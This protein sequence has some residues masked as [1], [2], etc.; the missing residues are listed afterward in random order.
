MENAS[1]INAPTPSGAWDTSRLKAGHEVWRLAPTERD[2]ARLWSAA[3]GPGRE[4]DPVWED[5]RARIRTGLDAFGFTLVRQLFPAGAVADVRQEADVTERVSR[6]VRDFGEIVPQNGAGD[7]TQVL[8]HREG[9]PDEIA[10]HC[11]TCDLLVL[12]CL[13]PAARGGAT[14]VAGAPYIHDVLAAERPDV[15]ELLGQEWHFDRSGRAGSQLV[16]TPILT[17][18]PDGAVTCYYQ[19]RTVR[20]SAGRDGRPPLDAARAEALDVLDEVLNRPETAYPVT[21]TSGDLLIIRNSRVMHGR[22]PFTDGPEPH[23]R[24]VLRL[25]LDEVAA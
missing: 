5:L 20:A 15:L 22:S 12:L 18:G 14:R 4:P 7:V 8:R 1:R 17:T 13:R 24:R 19:S 3:G 21:L 6:L 23:H 16:L 25:W 10:F 2:R 11:D 9:D